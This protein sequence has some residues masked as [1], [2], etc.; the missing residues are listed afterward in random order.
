MTLPTRL[1]FLTAVML[2]GFAGL[3]RGQ[4]AVVQP[5]IDTADN[6]VSRDV[7]EL[8]ATYVFGSDLHRSGNFGEQ[9]AIQSA[10]S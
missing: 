8:E 10:F 5:V 1:C 9:D 4:E 3:V 6:K 2:I 7:V